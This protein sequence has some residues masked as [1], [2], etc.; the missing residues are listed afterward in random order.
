MT[1]FEALCAWNIGGVSEMLAQAPPAVCDLCEFKGAGLCETHS[2]NSRR[3]GPAVQ[4][5]LEQEVTEH[6]KL[7]GFYE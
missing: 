1:H 2:V 6:E 4:T 3:C 5:W 7:F